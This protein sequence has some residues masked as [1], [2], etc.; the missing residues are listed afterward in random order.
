MPG[1]VFKAMIEL[2]SSKRKGRGIGNKLFGPRIRTALKLLWCT[3]IYGDE[4]RELRRKHLTERASG[5]EINVPIVGR[6]LPRTIPIPY[7]KETAFCAAS[8]LA[9][10]L[11]SVPLEPKAYVFPLIDIH[12]REYWDKPVNYNW[13]MAPLKYLLA[14]LHERRYDILSIRRSFLK[15]SMERLGA[16][17]TF[18][19]SGFTEIMSLYNTL[20]QEPD[21][22][23]PGGLLD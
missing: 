17:A 7:V 4:L 6:A 15:R 10:W 23:H 3:G 16:P 12:V 22:S 18:Y 13:P 20:R 19:L 14:K 8:E 21:W 2:I 1:S 11:D 5:F 9:M